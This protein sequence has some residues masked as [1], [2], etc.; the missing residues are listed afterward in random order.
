MQRS[1]SRPPGME[2]VE[3]TVMH[4][5][6]HKLPILRAECWYRSKCGKSRC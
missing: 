6:Y 2:A 3:L 5:E 4:S 1:P